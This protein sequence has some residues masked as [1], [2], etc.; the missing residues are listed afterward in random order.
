M[1][2][3]RPSL[4]R[5]TAGRALARRRRA[6][7]S[8]ASS[9]LVARAEPQR[10]RQ[11]VPA[12]Q[13]GVGRRRD[14]PQ[15]ALGR[16][17]RARV[18]D[19]DPAGDAAAAP[20]RPARLLRVLGRAVRERGAAG[21]DRRARARRGADA[22]DAGAEGRVGDCSSGRC[23]RT[24]C[25]T[26][27]RSMLL[28]LYVVLDGEH[29]AL[30]ERELLFV[31][32][33]GVGLFIFAFVSARRRAHEMTVDGLGPVR[34]L[35][36]MGRQGLGVMRSPLGAAVAI[37]LQT[38]GWVCQLLAVYTAMRAFDIHAP[39]PAAGV[40]LLLM[41]VVDDHP[42]LAGQRRRSS[43]SRSRPARRLRRRVRTRRRV[44]L[45]AA[46][47]RGVGR[48]RRR[49]DVPRARG[50]VVRDAA[51][52]ADGW[53][54]RRCRRGRRATEEPGAPARERAVSPAARSSH[55]RVSRACS[56]RA[57]L[58]RRSAV[59][60]REAGGRGE[61]RSPTVGRGRRTRSG[62][63]SRRGLAGATV[64]DPFGRPRSRALARASGRD[65]GGRGGRGD[66]PR[67]RRA[68][69]AG[70]APRVEPWPRRADPGD[71][72]AGAARLARRH[73]DGRR[74]RG[75]RDGV[76]SLPAA[77]RV[78]CD[79][80]AAARRGPAVRRQKGADDAAVAELERRLAADAELAPYADLPGAGAAGG[81][82][83]ALASL[84]AELVPGA[85]LVL[86][87]V[88]FDARFDGARW[89][90]PAR[91][92]STGRRGGQGAGRGRA[93]GCR[94][95]ASSASSSAGAWSSRWPASRRSR[96]PAIRRG[97]RRPA[98]ARTPARVAPARPGA[99]ALR[100][101]PAPC[102]AARGRTRTAPR[103]APRERGLVERRL[104]LL[105]P[106]DDLLEL[107]LR[108]LEG[109]LGCA[110]STSST[111]APKPPSASVTSTRTPGATSADAVTSSTPS[112]RSRTLV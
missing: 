66:R 109:L 47:D 36:T 83:A 88:G 65:G 70:S 9:A 33:V 17:A 110:H 27:S 3:R 37:F 18:D 8:S 94:P 20:G 93:P 99:L 34:R 108:L 73:G 60:F 98:G 24:A 14:R 22:E 89:S 46:G 55:R 80:L 38:L 40:V 74:R 68:G 53:T 77:T 69:G 35:W 101:C 84:G 30:G 48:H 56:R 16:R 82:G 67:S 102:R 25:S 81:L 58:L 54:R 52:D 31:I 28:V 42:V 44:R 45:R 12:G 107:R 72:R 75:L 96:S 13:V 5:S 103:P 76:P 11:R 86:D 50:P 87:A 26:S 79:S 21:T 112:G 111:R 63:G 7:R 78:A 6:R 32:G 71:G 64:A 15:P 1:K 41:N 62:R 100:P 85:A 49:P 39:L 104:A 59:G 4:P 2:L 106:L 19:G 95:A 51:R 43:R 29:P 10:D 97:R 91:A 105:Q 57:T 90:S 61:C 92:R 23:S